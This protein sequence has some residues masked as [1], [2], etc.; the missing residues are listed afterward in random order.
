MKVRCLTCQKIRVPKEPSPKTVRLAKAAV[1]ALRR[2]NKHSGTD[3]GLPEEVKTPSSD[4]R[5]K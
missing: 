2:V 1:R 5:E 3:S 4:S